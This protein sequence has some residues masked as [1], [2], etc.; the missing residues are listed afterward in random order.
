MIGFILGII[1]TWLLSDAIYSYCLYVNSP[2]WSSNNKQT[3]K[4]DHWVR[5]LRAGLSITIIVIVGNII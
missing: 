2:T 5:L 1:G 3:W 4:K